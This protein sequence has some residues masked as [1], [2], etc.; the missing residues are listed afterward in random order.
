MSD[1]GRFQDALKHYE[2]AAKLWNSVGLVDLVETILNP[3]I[4]E[5]RKHL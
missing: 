1:E 2:Q 5:A 4:E 3:R